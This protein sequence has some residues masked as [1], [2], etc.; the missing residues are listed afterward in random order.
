MAHRTV[1]ARRR[2]QRR[3][4]LGALCWLAV[5]LLAS[6]GAS[7]ILGGPVRLVIVRGHSM[8]PTFATGDLIVVE[9]LTAPEVGDVISYP[10]PARVGR[11]AHIIHRI[12]GGDASGFVT[13]GDNRTTNDPWTPSAGHVDGHVVAHLAGVGRL[14]TGWLLPVLAAAMAGMALT[15]ALWP[16]ADADLDAGPVPVGG[17]S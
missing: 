1:R 15:W 14:L 10:V 7:S 11:D 13:R 3:A 12:V 8:D 5:G 9:D 6:L 17:A 16:D 4:L 2:R